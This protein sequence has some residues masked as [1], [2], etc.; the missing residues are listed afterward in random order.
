MRTPAGTAA[1]EPRRR[2]RPGRR[3]PGRRWCGRRPGSSSA[4]RGR[5]RCRGPHVGH[6]APRARSSR[7]DDRET[8]RAAPRR[9]PAAVRR[10]ATALE[11][12]RCYDGVLADEPSSAEAHTYRGWTLVRTGDQRPGR[13]RRG[14]PRPGR[15]ARPRPTP[16]PG[17]SGPCCAATRAGPTRPGPTSPPSTRSTPPQLMRSWSTRWASA[18]ASAERRGSTPTV[19]GPALP[20]GP[21]AE[22]LVPSGDAH[23]TGAA[24]A[25]PEDLD[26]QEVR[27]TATQFWRPDPAKLDPE[28]RRWADADLRTG[29]RD[30]GAGGPGGCLRRESSRRSRRWP[31]RRDRVLVPGLPPTAGPF[32]T[33]TC[34]TGRTS[35][36]P[37]R[38]CPPGDFRVARGVLGRDLT[39]S[40]RSARG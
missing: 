7:G 21:R 25:A 28:V 2:R 11:A 36:P 8:A 32:A 29:V 15:G 38:P 17:C 9:L 5:R 1:P 6:A 37:C 23:A 24:A 34:S 35:S 16:T 4:G 30:P 12:V 27:M 33:S 19:E 20:T 39:S 3:G 14:Q 10:A 18:R 31:D 40:P 22:G 13:R 26:V